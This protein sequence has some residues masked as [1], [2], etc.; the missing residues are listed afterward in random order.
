METENR[1]KLTS[2]SLAVLIVDGL[3]EA[4]LIKSEDFNEAV[5]VATL[6]IE[7]RKTAGDY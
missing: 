5:K 7:I 1:K 6:E 2:E 4:K 3:V